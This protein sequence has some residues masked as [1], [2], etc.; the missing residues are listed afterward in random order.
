MYPLTTFNFSSVQTFPV[1]RMNSSNFR[2]VA[3]PD[4]ATFVRST[5]MTLSGFSSDGERSF[6]LMGTPTPPWYTR[7]SFSPLLRYSLVL[8]SGTR[9]DSVDSPDNS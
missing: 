7:I 1:S 6:I 8:L 3:L 4:F 5:S 2:N 9:G